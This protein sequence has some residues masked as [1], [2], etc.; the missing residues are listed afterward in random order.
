V[1]LKKRNDDLQSKERER[2][3]LEDEKKKVEQDLD[4]E[5]AKVKELEKRPDIPVTKEQWEKD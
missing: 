1:E 4:A 2:Q 5:K 3:R